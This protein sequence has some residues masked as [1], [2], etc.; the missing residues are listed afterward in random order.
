MG[1]TTF[2]GIGKPLPGRETIVLT[3]SGKKFD[4]AIT[5]SDI[6]EVANKFKDSN[7]ILFVAG[8]AS[9]YNQMYKYADELIISRIPGS[10]KGD[11]KLPMFDVAKFKLV[12]TIEKEGFEVEYYENI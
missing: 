3:S 7:N 11:V 8:G 9:V 4:G 5:D 10:H 6:T 12:N 1:R 2:E